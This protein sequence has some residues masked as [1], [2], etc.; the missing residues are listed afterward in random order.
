MEW[1]LY[2]GCGMFRS[3]CPRHHSSSC[4]AVVPC[5]ERRA[6][7]T[8]DCCL[9]LCSHKHSA[10]RAEVSLRKKLATV[11]LPAAEPRLSTSVWGG[12]HS[13]KQVAP[14]SL[15]LFSHSVV[16][17]SLQ[18]HGPQHARPP[19]PSP[20]PRACSNSCSSSR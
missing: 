5:Q 10:S 2:H 20:S 16:S 19:C 15:Q 8:P 12:K 14:M 3:L 9:P 11:P 17:D 7:G 13:V 6:K 18:P 4:K 1:R